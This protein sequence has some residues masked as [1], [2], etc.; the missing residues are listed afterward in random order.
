MSHLFNFYEY[1]YLLSSLGYT[2]N[3]RNV[4][5]E[6]LNE[7]GKGKKSKKRK[8]GKKGKKT[9]SKAGTKYPKSIGLVSTQAKRAHERQLEIDNIFGDLK[10]IMPKKLLDVE[11]IEYPIINK[12]EI[13]KPKIDKNNHTYRKNLENEVLKLGYLTRRGNFSYA[14]SIMETD[15]DKYYPNPDTDLY[16]QKILRNMPKNRPGKPNIIIKEN[17][18]YKRP[19]RKRTTYTFK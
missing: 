6:L 12:D 19:T 15:T 14:P 10:P 2:T 9:K 7:Y 3:K 13:S 8:K 16:A 4:I 5:P 18:N 17:L 11:T 1:P